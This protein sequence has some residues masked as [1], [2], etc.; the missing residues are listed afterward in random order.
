MDELV[1]Q[2]PAILAE[3]AKS[4]LG[5]FALMI[6]ALSIIGFF[7][8]RQSSE[9]TRVWVFVLMFLGVASFGV[10]AVRSASPAGGSAPPP[11]AGAA[12]A[13]EWRADVVYPW[14]ARHGETLTLRTV[15]GELAGTMSYLGVP[16]GIVEGAVEGNRITF[17]LGLE[18]VG[19]DVYT[20]RYVGTVG[21]DEIHFT[22]TDTRG[23]PPVEFVAER[24][25]GR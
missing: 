21:D 4:A 5:V 14:G 7:F 16:R 13:G 12:V 25:A 23:N 15:D 20:N 19:G 17:S 1:G 2:A 18:N 8:F 11:A 6:M 9:R 3:A 22:L 24:P 10:A